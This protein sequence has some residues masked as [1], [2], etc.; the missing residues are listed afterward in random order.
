MWSGR[1]L[2]LLYC[3]P[4]ALTE[5][6]NHVHTFLRGLIP[7]NEVQG[8]VGGSTANIANSPWF[9][10]F[11]NSQCGGSLISEDRVLTAAHCVTCEA[12]GPP[13]T[14]RVMASTETDGITVN[15][16]GALTH[17]NYDASKS[18]NDL[19]ILKLAS[20]VTGVSFVT[21]NSNPTYP[22]TKAQQLT[23]VGMGA[24]ITDGDQNNVLKTLQT[25]FVGDFSC[26][27]QWGF[28]TSENEH[29]CTE[30]AGGG[31][32]SGDSGGPLFDSSGVQVGVA[33]FV[34]S[35]CASNK[36]DVFTQV[37]T[38]YSW[39][40]GQLTDNSLDN[41]ECPTRGCCQLAYLYIRSKIRS[42]MASLFSALLGA[43]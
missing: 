11:G 27:L 23:V 35:K 42:G 38:Y 39:I 3:F 14:V 1:I 18:L 33:S 2:F 24:T 10:R 9:V 30:I 16:Q 15:V 37:S 28:F 21:L 36:P 29:L 17:P 43:E 31:A 40:Q 13:S 20:P 5:E 6:H 34:A 12:G 22:S 4:F 7:E 8:I 25:E 26:G 41:L 19:A 32:C